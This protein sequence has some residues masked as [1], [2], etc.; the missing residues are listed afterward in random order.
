M[1]AQEP[2][3]RSRGISTV[4]QSDIEPY[5]ALKWVGRLFKAASV[6]LAI[7]LAG[8]FVAGIR[9]QGT[10]I[11]PTLLGEVARTAVLAVVLW[12]GGDLVRLLAQL[13]N[14][15]RAQRILLSRLVYR[16]PSRPDD[17]SAHDRGESSALD[18]A[19]L[20]QSGDAKEDE[21]ARRSLGAS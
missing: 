19:G 13:G 7:A 20:L 12:G 4:R 1:S 16:T 17:G 15:I 2:Q 5:T 10:A 14:D 18:S 21:A 11:L 3:P 8:E 9:L 6:F